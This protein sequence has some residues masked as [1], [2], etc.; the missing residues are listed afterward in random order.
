[1]RELDGSTLWGEQDG[2]TLYVREQDSSTLH[3]RKQG[4]S[5]LCVETHWFYTVC[6]GK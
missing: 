3:V 2:S 6:E 4:G 5:Q 1:M